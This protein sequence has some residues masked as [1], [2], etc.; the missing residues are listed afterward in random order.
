MVV[1]HMLDLRVLLRERI[2]AMEDLNCEELLECVDAF[3]FATSYLDMLEN[4]NAK[5]KYSSLRNDK[6]YRMHFY[7]VRNEAQAYIDKI[8]E[9]TLR[10]NAAE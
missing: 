2:E 5:A 3:I 7:D 10:D 4:M 9:L 8:D 1:N 6:L